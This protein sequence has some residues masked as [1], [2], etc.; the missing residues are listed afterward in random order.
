LEKKKGG[1]K[2]EVI[3]TRKG[4]K[5]AGTGLSHYVSMDAK[6]K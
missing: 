1:K 6:K 5:P 4:C 3:A 2:K